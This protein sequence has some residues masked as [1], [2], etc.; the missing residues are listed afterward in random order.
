MVR[1]PVAIST[2]VVAGSDIGN[3]DFGDEWQASSVTLMPHSLREAARDLRWES[4]CT[5]AQIG[6]LPVG[7]LPIYRRKGSAFPAAFIDPAKVAPEIFPGGIAASQYA[8]IGGASDMVA[9]PAISRLLIDD[10]AAAVK[11][12]LV[13]AAYRWSEA[14]GL[15]GAALYVRQQDL[16]AFIGASGLARRSQP[17][18]ELSVLRLPPG[19]W[20]GYL[21]SLDHKRRSVV[22]RD[23]AKLND[24]KLALR[25]TAASDIIAE[26]VPLVRNIKER[27]GVPEHVDLLEARLSDWAANQVGERIAFTVRDSSSRL[28]AVSFGCLHGSVLEMCEIGLTD[29][30]SVRQ[31]VYVEVMLY[32]PIRLAAATG[33]EEITLGLGSVIP[34]KLRGATVTKVWAVGTDAK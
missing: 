31:L 16:T 5:I 25:V 27:H 13:D 9:G 10:M 14:S 11:R 21:A 12:S 4:L 28:I 19:G 32:S 1:P 2:S 24:L 30:P 20:E 18:D 8:L 23:L 22:K 15:V 17:V 3:K 33:S 6:S 26:S 7:L 34:K 29:D